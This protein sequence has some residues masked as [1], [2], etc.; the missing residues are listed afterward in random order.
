M[1]RRYTKEERPPRV[2]ARLLLKAFLGVF[3]IFLS[4]GAGVAIAGYLL[5]APPLPP[6]PGGQGRVAPPIVT[7]PDVVE[8]VEPGG[9]RSSSDRVRRARRARE[10]PAL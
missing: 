5:I 3:L 7:R 1:R 10:C 2:G 6:G 8:P 4:T 9:T